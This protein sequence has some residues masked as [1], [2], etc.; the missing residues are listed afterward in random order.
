VEVYGTEAGELK[1]DPED[2]VL[3]MFN[4]TREMLIAAGYEHYEIANFAQ[5]G[6]ACRHNLIYWHNEPYLGFGPAAHSYWRGRR[7]ANERDPAVYAARLA[8]GD[9]LP[10]AEIEEHDLRTE[11]AE[12]MFLGLRLRRG[13]SWERFGRRFGQDLN[14]VYGD[15]IAWLQRQGLVEVRDGHLRLTER[16]LPLANLA[17]EQFL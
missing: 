2:E 7:S 16:G 11:M 5:P 9:G 15:E 1:P 6:H 4:L 10:V 17:F 3:E 12:T 8:D 13:V 14:A